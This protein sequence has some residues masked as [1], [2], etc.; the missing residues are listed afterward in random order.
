MLGG[1]L[2]IKFGGGTAT[3]ISTYLAGGNNSGAETFYS[4]IRRYDYATASWS[5]LAGAMGGYR[6]QQGAPS[7]RG[8]NAYLGFG[9][10]TGGAPTGSIDKLAYATD[11][12]STFST[13]DTSEHGFSAALENPGTM[14][15]WFG[16]G[17]SG[18]SSV[19]DFA[20]RRVDFTTDTVTSNLSGL[21]FSMRRASFAGSDYPTAGIASPVTAVS[22]TQT[23]YRM[24]FATHVWSSWTTFTSRGNPPSSSGGMSNPGVATYSGYNASTGTAARGVIKIGFV[25]GTNSQI[26][27]GIPNAWDNPCMSY[28][29][30][31]SGYL[32][33]GGSSNSYFSRFDFTTETGTALTSPGQRFQALP[34]SN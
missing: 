20:D 30:G 33:G 17:T 7:D 19:N 34:T 8:V 11:T 24:V 15:Y 2:G 18:S 1:R 25:T 22:T 13:S 32:S 6:G 3:N 23:V 21:P 10:I 4:S 31:D 5:T 27:N 29:P 16:G 26:A 12:V 28:A 14:G 9:T